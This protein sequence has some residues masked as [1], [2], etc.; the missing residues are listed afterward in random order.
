MNKRPNVGTP[1]RSNFVAKP[2]SE[3]AFTL[4]EVLV[5]V[6]MVAVGVLSMVGAL[7]GFTKTEIAIRDRETLSRLVHDKLDEMV[8]TEGYLSQTGG[9][10]DGDEYQNFTWTVEEVQTGIAGLVGIRVTVT[11]PN[12]GDQTAETLV[13]RTSEVIDTEGEQ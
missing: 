13:F 8:A 9:S 2:S 11:S 3:K 5:A 1:G 6:F 4:V 7:S 10:F 12:L